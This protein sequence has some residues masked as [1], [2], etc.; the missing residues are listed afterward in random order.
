MRKFKFI[1]ILLFVLL[2]SGCSG[3]YNLKIN[4]DL[5]INESVDLTIDVSDGTYDSTLKLFE[6][7][8]ID[9]S[10]YKIVTSDDE[11][12]I[13]YNEDYDSIEDYILNSKLY[14]N[15]F[16]TIYYTNDRRKITLSTNGYFKLQNNK[17]NYIVNDYDV[18]L[19][20]INIET[21]YK[22]VENNAEL[23]NKKI[24]SWS[25]NKNTTSKNID[26]VLDI[27]NKS[28]SYVQIIVLSLIGLIV[29]SSLIFILLR[30]KK[31]QKI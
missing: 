31:G 1:A 4:E 18:S 19:I 14:K 3:T 9:E 2:L 11:I 25:L 5:T 6:D 26:I 7:N 24:Y 17:S 15:F 13:K 29:L 23:V 30:L 10:K 16:D 21:P 28:N 20:Q 8:K 12:N 22:V 27:N